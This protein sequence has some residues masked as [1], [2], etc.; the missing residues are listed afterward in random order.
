MKKD[1]KA[2]RP[3]PA[4]L[5]SIRRL[6]GRGQYQEA[7]ARLD[8]LRRQFPGFK[9]LYGLAWE[10]ARHKGIPAEACAA[11][12]DW[13][14]A[15]A[16][17]QP[18]W[19]ALAESA[20]GHFPSLATWAE[21][22]IAE[23]SGRQAGAEP[24]AKETRYGTVRFQDAICLES[25]NVYLSAGRFNE[26]QAQIGDMDYVP[27]RNN[28]AL[29]HFAKGDITAAADLLAVTCRQAP[30][31]LFGLAQRI[32]LQLWT[33]GM[34]A[35]TELL[36]DLPS[37]HAQRPEDLD[38]QLSTLILLDRLAEADAIWREQAKQQEK[39]S[40][41]DY[42][43]F[44]YVGA[45][46]A[47]RLGHR[48]EAL[49]RLGRSDTF[50]N[51]K[52]ALSLESVTGT[53]PDWHIGELSVWWPL[54]STHAMQRALA[55]E[56]TLAIELTRFAVHNDYLVRMAE[57][58]GRAGR[59]IA[60]FMLKH[61]SRLGDTG[62][63]AALRT[64]LVCPC[65]SDQERQHLRAWLIDEELVTASDVTQI[66]LNGEIRENKPLSFRLI[67][68]A[69]EEEDLPPTDAA[70]Y[71]E[72][73]DHFAAGDTAR[74]TALL[75]ALAQRHPDHPRVL[76]NLAL[77][78][79]AAGQPVTAFEIPARRAFEL[80]PDYAFA[81]FAVAY[82][83]IQQDKVD[84]ALALLPPILAREELHITEWRTCLGVQLT[85]ARRQGDTATLRNVMSLL[86][87]LE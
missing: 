31:N 14:Q 57:L 77:M 58:G 37:A 34:A 51:L 25:C 41:R 81:R 79:F 16:Q 26:A 19:S 85:A 47:W 9:P 44:P 2:A 63:I 5:D 60:S 39:D 10:I 30:D 86:R 66:W 72:A 15:S 84:E 45:Y 1:P 42:A 70:A 73:S 7:G 6:A 49:S 18:A 76:A 68:E 36:Q 80:A 29:I 61:R 56:P 55:D 69:M 38:G 71:E 13:T 35:A 23:L 78:M 32:R 20:L 4:Q 46:L 3:Q 8:S 43:Q 28:L 83:L 11:A 12:L 65:G 59:L 62:A 52:G 87:D 22:R 48:E 40:P 33:G 17:S 53:P 75:Q 27:A 21:R 64:L 67:Y 54:S 74:A 82:A 50:D 24:A